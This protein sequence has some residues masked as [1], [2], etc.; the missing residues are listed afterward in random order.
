MTSKI[1]VRIIFV[2]VFSSQISHQINLLIWIWTVN[3]NSETEFSA[4]NAFIPAFQQD[5]LLKIFPLLE[6][7]N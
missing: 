3:L 4:N 6:D 7:N 1:D 2:C 5:H